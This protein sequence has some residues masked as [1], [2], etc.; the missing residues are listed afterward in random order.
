VSW[1]LTANDL[2]PLSAALLSRVAVVQAPAPGPEFFDPLLAGI[3]RSIAEE[4]GVD[5]A[6]LPLLVPEARDR[7][8][9]GF[10]ARPDLRRIR[11]AVESALCVGTSTDQASR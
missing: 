1:L 9:R 2:A 10:I 5:A 4:L 11:R 8:R 7:L 6:A 3:L